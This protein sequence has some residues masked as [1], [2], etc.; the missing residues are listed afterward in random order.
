MLMKSRYLSLLENHQRRYQ[1]AGYLMGDYVKFADNYK[2][3]KCYKDMPPTMQQAIDDVADMG[4]N[5]NLRVVAVKNEYPSRSPGNE[6]NTNGS[7]V[8]DIALDYGGGRYYNV[9]TVPTGVVTRLDYGVNYAPLPAALKRDNMITIK[10][11]PVEMDANT[12]T[13]KQTRMT[14]QGGKIKDSD[15]SL[16]N[17][18][19]KIPA[20]SAKGYVKYLK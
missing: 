7:V 14:D 4:K 10:P 3:T 6:F 18:N 13:Y 19:E 17:K 15:D 20:S 1:I 16:K 11:E 2:S 12:D 9:I 8:L 5:M